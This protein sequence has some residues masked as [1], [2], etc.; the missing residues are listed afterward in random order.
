MGLISFFQDKPT[1]KELVFKDRVNKKTRKRKR[2]LDKAMTV[3]KV[4]HYA[5]LHSA[6]IQCFYCSS[7]AQKEEKTF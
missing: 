1:A 3:L 6:F 5:S 4:S 2:K 7:E